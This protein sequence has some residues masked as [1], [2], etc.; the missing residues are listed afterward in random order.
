MPVLIALPLYLLAAL[1]E[2]AVALAPLAARLGVLPVELLPVWPDEADF[3]PIAALF[4][5][6]GALLGGLLIAPALPRGCGIWLAP[7]VLPILWPEALWP[8]G[9]TV[10]RLASYAAIALALGVIAGRIG[11]RRLPVGL[12]RI[13]AMSGLSP[14]SVWWRIV[15][16][17]TLPPVTL[18]AVLALLVLLPELALNPPVWASAWLPATR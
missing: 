13:G 7:F 9:S 1:A 10:L 8:V 3:L 15:L 16:P 17:A 2:I 4:A 18:A 6:G 11:L 5:V 12:K 14:L